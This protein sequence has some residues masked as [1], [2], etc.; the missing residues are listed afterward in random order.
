VKGLFTGAIIGLM[1]DSLTHHPIGIY[2]IAKT[3]VGFGASS[4]GAKVDVENPGS[5][6]LMT[7]GFYLLHQFVYFIVSRGMVG[8]PMWW[9][10]SHIL[11]AAL[12][13]SVL[14]VMLFMV[15]DR[16]KEPA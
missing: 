6:F 9:Q 7:F 8:T 5:R 13:N 2:G 3:V 15:L 10:W 1:Q 12:L 4:I 16:V 11:S 14:A